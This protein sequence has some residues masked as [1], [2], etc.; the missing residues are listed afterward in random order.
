MEITEKL[1]LGQIQEY[2]QKADELKALADANYGAA[3]AC[4]Q[5]LVLLRMLSTIEAVEP[6]QP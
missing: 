3:Q 6:E 2:R 5:L 4:E 1:L